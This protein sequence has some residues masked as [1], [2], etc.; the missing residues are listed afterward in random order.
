MQDQN[1]ANVEDGALMFLTILKRVSIIEMRA[2]IAD[3]I[4]ELR[5]L[6]LTDVCIELKC[7]IP[8]FDDAVTRKVNCWNI[9]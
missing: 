4:T 1:G 5:Q 9:K 8:A 7:S 6:Q 3:I 2:I